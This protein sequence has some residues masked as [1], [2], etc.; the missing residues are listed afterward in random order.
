MKAIFLDRDGTINEDVGDLYQVEKL[1]FIP[2][3]IE[4]L[5]ILQEQFALFIVTNQ[6][7]IGRGAFSENDFIWFSQ[8]Y[9]SLLHREGV[10][11]RR[12]YF[13][14][15]LK[16]EQCACYKPNPYFLK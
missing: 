11:I 6:S 4:A 10:V 1:V 5:K 13:C 3:A 8:Y 7:G 16:G 2:D 14:P 15:H 12:T 9:S